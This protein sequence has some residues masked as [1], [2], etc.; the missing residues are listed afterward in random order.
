METYLTFTQIN[1]FIFCHCSCFF[2]SYSTSINRF[3]PNLID[4]DTFTVIFNLNHNA[5]TVLISL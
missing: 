3:I 5:I 4:I 1:D 2:F